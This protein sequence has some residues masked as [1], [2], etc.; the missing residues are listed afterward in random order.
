MTNHEGELSTNTTHV[1][2]PMQPAD[3]PDE[4]FELASVQTSEYETAVNAAISSCH[5]AEL[6]DTSRYDTDAGFASCLNTKLEDYK[7]GATIGSTT[8]SDK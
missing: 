5:K 2:L 1:K 6:Q 8:S 3:D 7:F 4:I